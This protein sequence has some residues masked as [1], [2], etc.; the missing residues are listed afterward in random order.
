MLL[1]SIMLSLT[2]SKTYLVETVDN[3][4]TNTN[5][6]DYHQVIINQGSGETGDKENVPDDKNNE[7]DKNNGTT[8]P[9]DEEPEGGTIEEPDKEGLGGTDNKPLA[10]P[11]DGDLVG[12]DGGPLPGPGEEAPD[13]LTANIYDPSVFP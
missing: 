11:G 10:E 2:R 12:I 7:P 3:A 4:D 9:V 6:Q 13:H 8:E 5:A 1:V